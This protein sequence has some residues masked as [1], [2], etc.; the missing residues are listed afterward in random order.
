MSVNQLRA[1]K[2][3]ST[4]KNI[5]GRGR[6]SGSGKTSGRGHNGQKSRS[7]GGVRTGFEG[8]QMP[9]YRRVA[10]RGF[11][12]YP[13]KKEYVVVNVSSLEKLYADGE[14]VNLQTLVQTGLVK[15]SEKL[16]KI[17]GVGDLKKKL[18]VSV[19]AVSASAKDKI[20]KAGGS[21]V[22]TAAGTEAKE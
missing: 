22:D 17:L 11:S 18:E 10:S 12:N 7:G 8:G 2:G 16:V 9:L 3:A 21:V 4:K 1:P 5:V 15:K 6:S 13:F 14:K 20:E 19:P